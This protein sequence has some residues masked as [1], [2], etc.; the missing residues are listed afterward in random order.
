M[1]TILYI[2]VCLSG[3]LALADSGGPY[4]AVPDARQAEHSPIF[5]IP[6]SKEPLRYFLRH[7]PKL[8]VNR[9]LNESDSYTW[10]EISGWYA[11][12]RVLGHVRG[13]EVYEVRYVSDSRIEQGLDF[14]D[15][16]LILA[17]G[18]DTGP[19][20]MRFEPIYFSTGGIS[21]DRRAEHVL[22]GDK[23]GAVKVT[24]FWSGTGLG[25]WRSVFLRGTEDFK[26][27]RFTPD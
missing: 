26:F 19:D 22:D 2:A 23:Y 4:E 1:S 3:T 12:F 9:K 17:R 11:S 24:D 14:A 18:F 7:M 27:E 16:I 20:S 21:Y 8:N 5:S 13:R 6:A 25:R 10:A 15:A